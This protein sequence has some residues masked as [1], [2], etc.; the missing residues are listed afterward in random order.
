VDAAVPDAPDHR[1]PP[2]FDDKAS[3]RQYAWDA[4][5]DRGLAAFP[6]PPHGRIPN[7]RGARDAAERLFTIPVFRDARCIKVNPDAPQKWVR[8]AALERGIRVLVP[9][10]KLT[11]GFH[12]LD[13][14]TID[15]ADVGAAATRTTMERHSR[16]LALDALPAI[17]AIVTGC[18]AVDPAGHRCGKGAGYSDLEWA[19]LME[20]GHA[21]VPVATT[22]HEVQVV[23]AFPADAN[24]LALHWIVT[25]KRVIEVAKP[26]PAATGID[27]SLLSE[28]DLE[29]MPILRE[30]DR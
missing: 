30:L 1:A 9:T 18:A 4:L 17:D 20:L 22:V 29:A 5:Q 10:P 3:A 24:D 12:L 23:G 2:R 11:G 13:P 28:A 8:R 6:F 14:A 21:P 7:F 15:P 26:P 25:P 16:V 19:I 27:W